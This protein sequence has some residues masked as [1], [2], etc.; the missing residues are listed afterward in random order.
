MAQRVSPPLGLDQV[1]AEEA[2]P[3]AGK[4]ERYRD[5]YRDI[6]S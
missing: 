1:R 2:L 3:L 4:G 5:K 6:V